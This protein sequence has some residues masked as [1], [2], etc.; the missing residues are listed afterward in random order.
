MAKQYFV[1]VDARPL[2][3]IGRRGS[4][5]TDPRRPG[6]TSTDI[7]AFMARNRTQ[8]GQMLV[9]MAGA[10]KAP[11]ACHRGQ[12]DFAAPIKPL[13]LAIGRRPPSILVESYGM[14]PPAVAI[15]NLAKQLDEIVRRAPSEYC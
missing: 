13:R 4:R 12:A 6:T 1:V 14:T 3:F 15:L 11:A 7:S 5:T 9:S 10:D 2:A 8:L